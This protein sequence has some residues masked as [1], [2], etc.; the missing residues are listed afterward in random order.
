VAL[1]VMVGL[2]TIGSTMLIIIYNPQRIRISVS[3][4]GRAELA[5]DSIHYWSFYSAAATSLSRRKTSPWPKLWPQI[6]GVEE[7][8]AGYDIADHLKTEE[9]P[10]PWNRPGRSTPTWHRQSG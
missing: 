3:P 6:G 5:I 1:P 10:M 7:T 8:F 2:F 9:D 4:L